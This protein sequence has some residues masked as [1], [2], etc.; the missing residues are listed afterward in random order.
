MDKDSDGLISKEEFIKSTHDPEFEKDEE[1][2]PV[3][4]EDEYSEDELKEYERQLAEEEERNGEVHTIEFNYILSAIT[5]SH[6][7]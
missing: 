1:W 4:D 6:G 7:R 3:V 2:K 5:W